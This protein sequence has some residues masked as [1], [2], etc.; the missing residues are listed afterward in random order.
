[1]IVVMLLP[2]K[3]AERFR[4]LLNTSTAQRHLL[5]DFQ[6]ASMKGP[7]KDAKFVNLLGLYI[8]SKASSVC[9]FLPANCIGRIPI[10]RYSFLQLGHRLSKIFTPTIV[11]YCGISSNLR[12]PDLDSGGMSN[13]LNTQLCCIPSFINLTA[14]L[15]RT[16]LKC[17]VVA[18]WATHISIFRKGLNNDAW[19]APLIVLFFSK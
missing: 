12:D 18:M 17:W 5:D 11:S 19:C 16:E 13:K 2:E 14:Q 8:L 15:Q 6:F 9:W 10:I 7:C 4:I 1:M 3:P